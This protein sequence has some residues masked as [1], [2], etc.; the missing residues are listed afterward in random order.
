[1]TN[2]ATNIAPSF[3]S[4][5]TCVLPNMKQIEVTRTMNITSMSMLES[6]GIAL[7]ALLAPNTNK[8]LKM[9][10][11]MTLPIINSFSPFFKA[12]SEVTSSGKEVPIA[13]M[14]KPTNVSLIPRAIAIAEALSTTKSPPRMIPI[15]PIKIKIMLFG[16]EYF[17]FST[18][19]A[20]PDLRV[21]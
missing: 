11:P 14:V 15:S 7:I 3:L 2:S 8:M 4:N 21:V 5:L 19:F 13:T 20:L 12:V 17:G 9:F 6:K 18:S 16:R 1:M 10:D